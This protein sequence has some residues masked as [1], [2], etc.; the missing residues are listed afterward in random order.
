MRGVQVAHALGRLLAVEQIAQRRGEC[1]PVSGCERDAALLQS[2]QN[3][4]GQHPGVAFEVLEQSERRDQFGFDLGERLAGFDA[5]AQRHDGCEGVRAVRDHNTI[6]P[7][8]QADQVFC[9]AFHAAI[10]AGGNAPGKREENAGPTN[11]KSTNRSTDELQD[12][13]V[14]TELKPNAVLRG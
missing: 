4:G 1:R 2:V 3:A 7:G 12:F 11:E 8:P 6:E 13:A 9:G 10:L 5:L 14:L